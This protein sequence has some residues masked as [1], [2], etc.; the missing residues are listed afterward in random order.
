MTTVDSSPP[1]SIREGVTVVLEERQLERHRSLTVTAGLVRVAA[2]RLEQDPLEV[3]PMTLGFLQAGDQ[4]ALDLLWKKRLHLQALIDS[5]L[6]ESGRIPPA[7]D[8]NSLH[9]WTLEM[10]LIRN[11]SD[12][13]HRIS[14]LLQLLVR[15]FG[16]RRGAWYELSFPMTHADLAELCGHTRVTVSRQ[17]SRWRSQGLLEQDP[18]PHRLL[19]LAPDL[20]ES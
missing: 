7:A 10:L 4:L 13:E 5:R 14:A 16:R 19:R 9:D 2:S 11:L 1:L 17:F 8:G 18:G 3:H 15:R 6:E 20:V 12:A